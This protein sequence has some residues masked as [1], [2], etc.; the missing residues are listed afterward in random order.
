MNH[1]LQDVST[2][3]N[4]LIYFL[5]FTTD[6]CGFSKKLYAQLIV[7]L[8]SSAVAN[9]WVQKSHISISMPK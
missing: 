2:L 4:L 6:V 7:A 8:N 1:L 9:G 5:N 3:I